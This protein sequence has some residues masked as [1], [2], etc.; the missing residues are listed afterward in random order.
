MAQQ[1]RSF[2]QEEEQLLVDRCRQG[3][4]DSFA[5]LM[6]LHQKQ[7]YNFTYRM[8]GSEE[9]AEDLTQ[10]IFVAAFRGIRRFRGEAKF[11]T[12]LYRIALN[13]TR[14]RIKYLARR[15][16][17]ARQSRRLR[18]G[19]ESPWQNPELL[20]DIA[21]TPEQWTLSKSLAIQV[22]SCLNQMA[23]QARQILLL[24]DVQGFSYEELS[25]MLS[26]NPGTVKSRLHR[27][28]AALQEC[29]ADKLE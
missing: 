19:E 12:W 7:I 25:E 18:P 14:N 13:Q 6:R 2:K 3:D 9:E 23:P 21:P 16:F 15:D 27:A 20:A 10:D 17:F 5:E 22:Q 26:L 24:R 28:R 4:R 1:S 29:L 11:S 8:L